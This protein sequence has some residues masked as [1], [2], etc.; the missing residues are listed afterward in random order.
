MLFRYCMAISRKT[1]ADLGA[2]NENFIVCG[3][4][5]EICIRALQ[6]GKV[7]IYDPYVKLYHY[8][9]KSRDPKD[10]PEVDFTL[11]HEM[12]MA[13]NRLKDPYYNDNLDYMSSVPKVL[14][15]RPDA[16]GR[17]K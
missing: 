3:S 9:S 15:K 13:Y 14:V 17:I 7:N 10:I 1:I 6:S 4:D 11:S 16:A 8:E 12:Y 5:I 2:F